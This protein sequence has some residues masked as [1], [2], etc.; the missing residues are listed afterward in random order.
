MN[1]KLLTLTIAG[2]LALGGGAV[3]QAKERGE[4][5]H[6]WKGHGG[7]MGHGERMGFKLGHLTKALDLTPQQQA[8][9][10]PIIEQLKPQ[11]KAIHED[12]MKKAQAAMA[13]SMAKIRPLLTP[14]QVQKLDK[15][16]AAHEKMREAHE[17]MREARQ[18]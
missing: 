15:M 9:V 17:A 8:Q 10:D 11:I 3:L 7:K 18:E 16:K 2:A 6:G 4:E 12:A 13:E 5:G 1:R 14:E